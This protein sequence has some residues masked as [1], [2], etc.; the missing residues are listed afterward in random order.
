MIGL[1][2]KYFLLINEHYLSYLGRIVVDDSDVIENVK[3]LCNR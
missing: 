3:N 1:I 2:T